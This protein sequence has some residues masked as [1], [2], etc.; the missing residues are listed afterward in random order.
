MYLDGKHNFYLNGER[1]RFRSAVDWSVYAFNGM[2]P[3]EEVAL[4]TITAVKEV[5]HNSLNFHRLAGDAS[6]FNA[7]D[8]HGVY[9][10]E[11]PGGFHSG[12][13]GKEKGN[14]DLSQFMRQQMYE[15]IKRMVIRDR[16]H[17]SLLI[18]TL[19]NED[20]IWS[21]ARKTA[22]DII[23]TLDDSRLIVNS[24]GGNGGG[25]S[26]DG[27]AHIR[28]YEK[29]VRFDYNDHHTVAP[30]SALFNENELNADLPYRNGRLHH[31]VKNENTHV[32]WG[33][34]RCYAGT[35]NYPLIYSQGK[36][37]P[38]YELSMYK[39]QHDKLVELYQACRL[40]GMGSGAI[41]SVFDLTKQAGRGQFYANG[42]LGQVIMSDEKSGGYAINGWTPG[43]DMKD[44][45]ASAMLDQN[46]NINAPGEDAS[47]W[48]R[49][50]Q[51]A[52]MRQ[53]GKYFNPNDTVKVNL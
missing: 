16:N 23:H 45:W 10:Y 30:S 31:K 25:R 12:G 9:M 2:F 20:N 22:M 3:T 28:P 13:Q 29:Q 14:I 24:S 1:I 26:V 42:R 8:T 50:L 51:V 53:N 34:V 35:F 6:V 18:Y 39:S 46:R 52:I 4:K 36:D 44:E 7:A 49:P 43:S 27:M 11:E 17:P 48:N 5:G 47:Y 37:K 21:D 38:G 15:R 19:C 32:Y 40:E 33:E 41:K